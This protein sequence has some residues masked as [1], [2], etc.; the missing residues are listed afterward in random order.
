ME[1]TAFALEEGE[2]CGEAALGGEARGFAGAGSGVEG[3]FEFRGA[4][5]D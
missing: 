3:G 4:E 5:G 1:G 2:V